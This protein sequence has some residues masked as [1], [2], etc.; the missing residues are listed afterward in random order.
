M[1]LQTVSEKHGT[2]DVDKAQLKD[3]LEDRMLNFEEDESNEETIV[4]Q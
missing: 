3:H 4:N 1:A 2:N